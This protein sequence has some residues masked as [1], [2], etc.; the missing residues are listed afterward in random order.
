MTDIKKSVKYL[1]NDTNLRLAGL[2]QPRQKIGEKGVPREAATPEEVQPEAAVT[3]E[4]RYGEPNFE[5]PE[6]FD[7]MVD[8][9]LDALIFV[10]NFC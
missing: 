1:V 4:A 5:E 3:G 2:L 7:Q 10:G 9:P 6:Y 8:G